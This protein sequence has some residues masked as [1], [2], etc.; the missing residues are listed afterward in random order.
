VQALPG[1]APSRE[2]ESEEVSEKIKHIILYFRSQAQGHRKTFTKA[3]PVGGKNAVLFD[4]WA[5][6]LERQSSQLTQVT[7]ERDA[8]RAEAEMRMCGIGGNANFESRL[9]LRERIAQV[10]L[11]R[12]AWKDYAGKLREALE[13]FA[14][15]PV[16]KEKGI[17]YGVNDTCITG[18]DFMRA[19]QALALKMPGVPEL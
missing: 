16:L 8:L 15:L 14:L 10:T 5:D 13:P 11:E 4:S 17:I 3:T 7:Q 2:R 1:K 19:R 18:E 12:D 9:R 6:E